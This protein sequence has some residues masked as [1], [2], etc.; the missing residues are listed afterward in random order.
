LSSESAHSMALATAGLSLSPGSCASKTA[1][2]LSPANT[3]VTASI[4]KT[5]SPPGSP[6]TPSSSLSSLGIGEVV[7]IPFLGQ[8][9]VASDANPRY[10]P[11]NEDTY[12][13]LPEL[14]SSPATPPSAAADRGR[15]SGPDRGWNDSTHG[16][17]LHQT[18]GRDTLPCADAPCASPCAFLAIY[19]GHGGC[20]A[21]EAA[22]ASLHV[23]FRDLLQG[24]TLLRTNNDRDDSCVAQVNDTIGRCATAEAG[25][26]LRSPMP[27][28]ALAA[29]YAALDVELRAAR[30]FQTGATA[31]TVYCH[32]D[33]HV[34]GR[35]VLTTANVG[36]ARAV[37]CRAGRPLRLSV[38]H[39]A[40]DQAERQRIESAGGFVL[41]KRVNGVLEV[42]RALG[43]HSL[44]SVVVCTPSLRETVICEADEFL[45][46]ACDGLWDWIDDEA[47]IALASDAFD[48]GCTPPDV[49]QTLV[50]ASLA[51]GCTD[52]ISVIVARFDQA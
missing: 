13:L 52:N 29:A 18:D 42:S 15:G 14:L 36:D 49:A 43:D 37:L 41:A 50:D 4:P 39:R 34:A 45:I 31:V 11:T 23:K 32:A 46:L 2:T 51:A 17:L 10:R 1:R 33:P 27:M 12:V 25:L 16:G 30:L 9:G 28:H 40:G 44:K 19:D 22:A 3:V 21:A 20:A 38:D 47:A 5:T 24:T 8:A 26:A 6:T 7:F 48:N 35:R